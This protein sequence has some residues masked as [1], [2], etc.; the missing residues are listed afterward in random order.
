MLARKDW[1]GWTALRKAA[2][3]RRVATVRELFARGAAVDAAIE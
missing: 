2:R 1:V 3:E